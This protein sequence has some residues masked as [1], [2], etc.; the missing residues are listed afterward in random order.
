ML[1]SE[2][3]VNQTSDWMESL[4]RMASVQKAKKD[5]HQKN[6]EVKLLRNAS[7]MVCFSKWYIMH[8]HIYLPEFSEFYNEENKHSF[9]ILTSG[10]KSPASETIRRGIQ[11]V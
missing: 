3:R 4:D 10:E 5:F 2:F 7:I 11:N 8:P 1:C 9:C 6:A